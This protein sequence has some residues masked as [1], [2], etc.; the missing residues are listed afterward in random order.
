[1]GVIIG[2]G[3]GGINYSIVSACSTSA[4]AIGEA[5]NIIRYGKLDACLVGGADASITKF[6]LADFNNMTTLS[7][8]DDPNRASMPFDKDRNNKK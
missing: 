1:M 3:V 7:R 5:F 8:S 6:T 2:S 4:H